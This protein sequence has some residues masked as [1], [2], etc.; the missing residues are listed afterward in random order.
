MVFADCFTKSRGGYRPT[1]EGV[2]IRKINLTKRKNNSL[3]HPQNIKI[4]LTNAKTKF[5]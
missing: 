3:F 1:G 2:E 4:N 5:E